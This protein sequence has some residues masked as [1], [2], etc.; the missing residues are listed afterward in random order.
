MEKYYVF[1]FS[2][3]TESMRFFDRVKRA[4]VPAVIINTPRIITLGCGLSVKIPPRY[5]HS[6]LDLFDRSSYGTFLGVYEIN[7]VGGRNTARRIFS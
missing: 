7:G 5:Y 1:A 4:G 2:A 3:R 6:A